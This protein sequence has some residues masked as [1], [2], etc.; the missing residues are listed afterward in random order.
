MFGFAILGGDIEM[1][2]WGYFSLP[3]LTGIAPL[4]ID[5]A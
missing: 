2:E 1:S 5:R 3:E 4:N